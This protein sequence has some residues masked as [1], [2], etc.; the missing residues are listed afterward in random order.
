MVGPD[1]EKPFLSP[2]KDTYVRA[3]DVV[4]VVVS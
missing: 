1:N 3:V 2:V 4:A